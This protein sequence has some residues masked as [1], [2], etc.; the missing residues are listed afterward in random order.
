MNATN[1]INSYLFITISCILLGN[2]LVY[3]R[4]CLTHDAKCIGDDDNDDPCTGLSRGG[5][6]SE[7]CFVGHL[8]SSSG[9]L[10]V[11][12]RNVSLENNPSTLQACSVHSFRF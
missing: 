3:L 2:S 8:S 5:G 9:R 10:L 11:C 6:S 4:P 7:P 12:P 1:I